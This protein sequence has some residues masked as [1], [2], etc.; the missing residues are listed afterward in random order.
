MTAPTRT[1]LTILL[2][3]S[4]AWAV[5]I[6][7]TSTISAGPLKEFGTVDLT[8]TT[9]LSCALVC[10]PSAPTLHFAIA[11]LADLIATGDRT[12]SVAYVSVGFAAG[13]QPTG[14]TT[15]LITN[16]PA[17]SSFALFNKSAT[18]F[19]GGRTG[20]GGYIDITSNTISLPPFIK[21]ALFFSPGKVGE[22]SAVFIDA[23]PTGAEK[24]T[25]TLKGGGLDQTVLLGAS[26]CERSPPVCKV[27]FT[28]TVSGSL[29]V[30]ATTAQQL[31]ATRT[32]TI[33]GTGGSG[34][35]QAG[36]GGGGGNPGG[37]SHLP[38]TLSLALL[39]LGGTLRRRP[40]LPTSD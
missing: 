39:A 16:L 4:P 24:L 29:V 1:L 20:E 17:G 9:N 2:L 6:S 11:G 40:R 7:G 33:E 36:S 5:D 18:C 12:V 13:V 25:V 37:C 27:P 34:G 26:D 8:L 10:P 38:G 15:S 30:T 21:N 3:A 19:C 22:M 28:P 23:L 14:S 35:G 31:S 32:F